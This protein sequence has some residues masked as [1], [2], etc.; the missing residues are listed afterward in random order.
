MSSTQSQGT[1]LAYMIHSEPFRKTMRTG[2]FTDFMDK[3]NLGML[4]R[5]GEQFHLNEI[6][7][8]DEELRELKVFE[9][10]VTHHVKPDGSYNV[11][12]MLL[13][14]EWVRAFRHRIHG[15]PRLIREKEFRSVIADAFGVGI[16]WDESR[17]AVFPGLR[18]VP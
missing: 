15:F 6:D 14:S 5:Y 12:C 4:K 2:L 18:F 13:W 7:I 16:A 1:S 10:F 11:Q 8:G 9:E 3:A 17:G